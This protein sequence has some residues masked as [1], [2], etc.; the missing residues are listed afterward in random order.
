[1]IAVY[2]RILP[3]PRG[4][5]RLFHKLHEARFH[6]RAFRSHSFRYLLKSIITTLRHAGTTYQK[7]N[8]FAHDGGII[9]MNAHRQFCHCPQLPAHATPV[10]IPPTWGK[11]QLNGIYDDTDGGVLIL[12]SNNNAIGI[13][14][15]FHDWG[16]FEKGSFYDLIFYANDGTLSADELDYITNTISQGELLTPPTEAS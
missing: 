9:H 1:M 16:C 13:T 2:E 14:F 15:T 4:I 10:A 12:L 11:E 7:E 8:W 3:P 5:K 6:L